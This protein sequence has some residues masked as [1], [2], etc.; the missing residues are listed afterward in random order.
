MSDSAPETPEKPAPHFRKT[1]QGKWAVMGPVE[2]LQEAIDGDGKVKV[3]KKSGDWSEF[4]VVSLGRPFDVDGVQMAYG[5]DDEGD[6]SAAGGGS[7][8]NNAGSG[9][10][11]ST[12]SGVPRRSN[13]P[14]T[15]PPSRDDSE[16]LPEYQGG[17][18][19]EWQG[20]F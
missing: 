6:A 20:E 2:T 7:A 14:S 9:P 1:K 12:S 13:A 10:A 17:A 16:P 5:Y 11:R 15:P 18:E 3:L 8:A 4:T 19:D